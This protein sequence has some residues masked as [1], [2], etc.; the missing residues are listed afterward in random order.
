[1]ENKDPFA[2]LEADGTI[3]TKAPISVQ[4]D[5]VY[6]SDTSIQSIVDSMNVY[7]K[8]VINT[9]R[10]REALATR[11]VEVAADIDLDESNAE[12]FQAKLE[13]INTAKNLLNDLDKAARDHVTTKLKQKD[14]DTNAAAGVNIA[15]FLSKIKLTNDISNGTAVQTTDQIEQHLNQQFEDTGV[16]VL[17]SELEM[18]GNMLPPER[19]DPE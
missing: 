18:G 16:I 17:D 6:N 11:L 2:G 4:Y 19:K 10:A 12:M 15:E 5:N 3:V 14:T 1:M 9:Q 13:A 8:N 7:D